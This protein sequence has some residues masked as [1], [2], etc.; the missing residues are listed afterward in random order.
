MANPIKSIVVKTGLPISNDGNNLGKSE[1]DKVVIPNLFTKYPDLPYL[2]SSSI[3]GK[4]R[5]ELISSILERL[6]KI[7]F[8]RE[9]AKPYHYES[10][11]LEDYFVEIINEKNYLSNGTVEVV[12]YKGRT[13]QIL[14]LPFYSVKLFELIRIFDSTDIV[15]VA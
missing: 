5:A 12:N 14:L 7:P 4:L 3:K 2:P 13:K 9:L 1:L 8:N 11:V 6:W 15:L 10:N